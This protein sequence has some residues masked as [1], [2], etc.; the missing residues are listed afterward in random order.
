MSH[1]ITRHRQSIREALAWKIVNTLK[2]VY[3]FLRRQRKPWSITVE[4]MGAM[5]EGSL[6]RD[7]YLFLEE[8]NLA[9]M[10]RAE[11]HDVHHVLFGYGTNIK[12]ETLVQFVPLGNGKVSLP[13]L[14]STIV[15][16]L[17][18]PEYWDDFY[19]A[20]QRGRKATTF[21]NW[22]FESLLTQPTSEI[23]YQIFGNEDGM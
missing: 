11:F 7:V 4:Q 15:S 18:Y 9:L 21:Y 10:P 20:F 17:F 16:I 2:P 14:A 19:K 3:F 13:Y 5:P 6:G 22:D 1:A 8:N 23:R 12:D